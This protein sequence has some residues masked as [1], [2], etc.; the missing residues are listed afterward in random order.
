MFPNEILD[1]GCTGDLEAQIKEVVADGYSIY[2]VLANL[3]DGTGR[4]WL[5]ALELDGEN[6]S[7]QDRVLLSLVVVGVGA[8]LFVRV[9]PDLNRLDVYKLTHPPQAARMNFIMQEG[10][11]WCRQN[12]PGLEAS[13]TESRFKELMTVAREATLGVDSVQVWGHQTAFLLTEEGDQYISALAQGVNA[14]KQS[15]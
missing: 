4:S 13:M 11:H 8:Y 1:S 9:R 6:V 12:R 5:T 7:V 14:Y 2:H 3:L 10:M 15:L